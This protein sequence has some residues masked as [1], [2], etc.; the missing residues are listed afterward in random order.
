MAIGDLFFALAGKPDP[1]QQLMQALAGGAAAAD[2]SG[3]PAPAVS[4]PQ[5]A[6]MDA[7]MAAPAAPAAATPSTPEAYKSPPDLS[8]LYMDLL[9]REDANRQIDR[10]IG[11]IGAA[12]AHPEH[13]ASIL[14]AM[15]VGSGGSGSGERSGGDLLSSVVS[16]EKLQN[17]LMAQAQMRAA[18]PSIAKRYNMDIDTVKYLFNSGKLDDVINELQKPNKQIVKD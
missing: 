15:G 3:T 1:R 11:L 4:T 9:K 7:G 5:A 18:L 6:G 2:T 17:G 12:F 10:G 14:S 13:K 16:L 8:K